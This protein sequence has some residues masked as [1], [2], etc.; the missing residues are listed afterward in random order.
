MGVL[1]ALRELGELLVEHGIE[2][3]AF[4][5]RMPERRIEVAFDYEMLVR[6]GEAIIETIGRHHAMIGRLVMADVRPGS[7]KCVLHTDDG[8][9]VE[10]T[11]TDEVSESLARALG[12][13]VL[14]KGKAD[15]DAKAP[16]KPISFHIME[17]RM[18]DLPIV[19]FWED[20]T[21]EQIARRQGVRPFRSV[22]EL[23]ADF[24]P[25]DESIDDF[26]ETIHRWR[27][28]D[29]KY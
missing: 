6:I 7:R 16:D 18:I 13:R 27:E 1:V 10:C 24:W 26:I 15:F 8:D 14:V 12:H 19:A 20:L 2:R 5:L 17:I 21:V 23:K 9:A 4:D 11:Y 25:E 29:E 3:M 28:E 22:E